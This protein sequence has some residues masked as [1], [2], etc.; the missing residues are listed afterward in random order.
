METDRLR[1]KWETDQAATMGRELDQYR[2]G[3]ATSGVHGQELDARVAQRRIEL[4]DAAAVEF[5]KV[6]RGFREEQ[7]ARRKATGRML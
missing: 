1:Q 2:Y 3:L 4:M 5:A 7:V 6:L